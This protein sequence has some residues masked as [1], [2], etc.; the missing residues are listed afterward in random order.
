VAALALAGARV[1]I[2]TRSTD[3]DALAAA[4]QEAFG[5]A[6]PAIRLSA[7]ATGGRTQGR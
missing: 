7:G 5:L 1:V 6:R 4:Q 3:A 2:L